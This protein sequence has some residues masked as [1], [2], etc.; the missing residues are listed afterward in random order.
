MQIIEKERAV[1]SL[2]LCISLRTINLNADSKIGL[3]KLIEEIEMVLPD[4]G[5]K[6]Y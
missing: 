2:S 4:P 5:L 6:V 1:Q 3:F